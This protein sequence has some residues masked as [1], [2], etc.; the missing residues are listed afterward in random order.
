MKPADC[1]FTPEEYEQLSP[2]QKKWLEH[3]ADLV[4]AAIED[5]LYDGR[6]VRRDMQ[7]G[8]G[9]WWESMGPLT[10]PERTEVL[11]WLRSHF[12]LPAQ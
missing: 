9:V 5:G 12:D 10:P 4:R 8:H 6:R 7:E 11:R 3:R 1:G 2:Q